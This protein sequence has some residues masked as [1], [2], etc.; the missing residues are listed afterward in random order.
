MYC[1]KCG[2]KLEDNINF[3]PECGEKCSVELQV[4]GTNKISVA[5]KKK[6]IAVGIIAS[7][8]VAIIVIV[9]IVA[10]SSC[11]N[12]LEDDATV[13]QVKT[14][15]D[16]ELLVW[17]AFWEEASVT[18]GVEYSD[19]KMTH[20]SYSY[21]VDYETVEGYISHYYLI[22]TA[23]EKEDKKG[24]KELHLVTARCYY[25]PEFSDK[26]YLTFMTL[27]SESVL[28]DEK[29]EDWLMGLAKPNS[30]TVSKTKATENKSKTS[31]SKPTF[32]GS[33]CLDTDT[34][35]MP[36]SNVTSFS[37]GDYV[38]IA[39]KLS[40]VSG[41]NNLII[42]WRYPDGT[43]EDVMQYYMN[44]NETTNNGILADLIGNGS[45]S[46][47]VILESTGEEL[48]CYYYTVYGV[49]DFDY[50]S[51]FDYYYDYNYENEEEFEY[52]PNEEIDSLPGHWSYEYYDEAP[53]IEYPTQPDRD[54]DGILTYLPEEEREKIMGSE[55]VEP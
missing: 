2:R 48:C 44:N 17:R 39:G 22:N 16:Y 11:N 51:D 49:G 3:C 19:Y 13:D 36:L 29:T 28:F 52:V 43:V 55:Q 37:S 34:D 4:T 45:G 5:D 24:K 20:T 54:L 21:I 15:E 26:V 27:D 33:T 30:E 1:K 6:R 10:V 47:S 8:L 35:G 18:F 41:E 40:G 38:I 53:D 14:G 9:L 31:K 32:I 42:R 12:M 23:F 7:L 25:V 46:V 50:D